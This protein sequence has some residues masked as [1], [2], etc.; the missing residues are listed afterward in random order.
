MD[1]NFQRALALT[2]GR[3]VKWLMVGIF[4]LFAGVVM[5][6]ESVIQVLAWFKPP[7]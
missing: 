4:G 3:A 1:R 6:G 5:F 2:V 7:H